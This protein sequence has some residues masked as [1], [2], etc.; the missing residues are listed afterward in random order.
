MNGLK[1][2]LDLLTRLPP[3]LPILEK[4]IVDYNGQDAPK[5]FKYDLMCISRLASIV[6][7]AF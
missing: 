3:R 6:Y 5:E 7:L 4:E 2:P 1:D